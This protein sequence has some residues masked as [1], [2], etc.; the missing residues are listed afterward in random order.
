MRI[1]RDEVGTMLN[2]ASVVTVT[3]N[4]TKT[5]NRTLDQDDTFFSG[6]FLEYLLEH[7]V[8]KRVDHFLT[9]EQQPFVEGYD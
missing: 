2:S 6:D 4:I 7:I 1:T 8:S 3:D 5:G 9:L